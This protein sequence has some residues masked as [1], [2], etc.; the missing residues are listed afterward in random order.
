MA[1]GSFKDNIYSILDYEKRNAAMACFPIF[2]SLNKELY[3]K[4]LNE[5]C[6]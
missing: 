2:N 5:L 3:S 4:Y 1:R 6:E